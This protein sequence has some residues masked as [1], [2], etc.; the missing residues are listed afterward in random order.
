MNVMN[1]QLSFPRK[2]E[3]CTDCGGQV[4]KIRKEMGFLGEETCVDCGELAV[5]C[6][7]WL[8]LYTYLEPHTLMPLSS[9]GV[10][11]TSL[12][13]HLEQHY[14]LEIHSDFLETPRSETPQSPSATLRNKIGYRCQFAP[15]WSSTRASHPSMYSRLQGK[16][17]PSSQVVTQIN[18]LHT[19]PLVSM[20]FPPEICQQQQ[21]SHQQLQQAQHHEQQQTQQQKHKQ[22]KPQSLQRKLQQLPVNKPTTAS[23]KTPQEAKTP[24]ETQTK[25]TAAPTA[26]VVPKAVAP[27]TPKQTGSTGKAAA[28]AAPTSP[29]V[30]EAVAPEA[31]VVV[32]AAATPTPTA[33]VVPKA[34]A[35]AAAKE[36]GSIGKAAATAAPTAA[37]TSP[38]VPEAVAPAA[39]VAVT[40]PATSTP[41]AYV[42]P[43]AVAPAAAK[44]TGSIGK[45]A[46][47]AA[48]TA[49]PTSPAVPEAVA[50]A[51]AVAVVAPATPTPTAYVVPKAVAPAAAKETGSIGKAA[52]T[53]APTAAPTS[54]AVPE[55]V[56]PAAAVAVVAPATPTPTAYVVPKAVAPAAA[57]ETGSIGKAA[58]TAAPTSPAVPEAV[59]PAAAVAVVAAAT[60]TPTAYVVP[61]A[62][63]PATAKETGSIGKAAATAAPTTPT[64]PKAVALA[65]AQETG[66]TGKA[67]ATAASAL[68]VVASPCQQQST[69]KCK[70]ST[71]QRSDFQLGPKSSTVEIQKPQPSA[72]A[73]PAGAQAASTTSSQGSSPGQQQ[74][75]HTSPKQP[76]QRFS[77]VTQALDDYLQGINIPSI[78]QS[79]LQH[80]PQGQVELGQGASGGVLMMLYNNEHVAVKCVP[81]GDKDT[82]DREVRILSV[83]SEHDSFPNLHGTI[84]CGQ[85]RAVA[86]QFIG[87]EASA[88]C[89]TLGEALNG[90]R[91][92][93]LDP[94]DW[95]SI[96]MNVV[97]GIKHMH[98][99]G[100]LHNDIKMD[101]ILMS[102][103]TP[104]HRWRA[105]V[106]DVG[107]ATTTINPRNYVLT[108][109]EKEKY[110]RFHGH[111]APEMVDNAEHQSIQS[112]I[113]QLGFVLNSIGQFGAVPFLEQ[114]G[115][116]C[117][118]RDPSERPEMTHIKYCIQNNTFM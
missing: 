114:L 69:T 34:V 28:T 78:E 74:S 8:H 47:T 38:A 25:P 58:A 99:E 45:A 30:P 20:H 46:A 42:V 115:D 104:T 75:E 93:T 79:D 70:T 37:P 4:W 67:A 72:A 63:A 52:A 23:P 7:H 118:S 48:P 33:Y 105:Y 15:V 22:Q 82:V 61:K 18:Q 95:R 29:A 41:T 89:L 26:S 92:L 51:A 1:V 107:M 59:A 81:T 49:A 2:R 55:A 71:A 53:A 116:Q 108:S 27:P 14:P 35:P 101:N 13:F 94:A 36:T 76:K 56:A 96:A 113:F 62:V 88:T 64:V 66:S 106:I 10:Q 32:V 11:S 110:R 17:N 117:K 68:Y 98:S 77:P 21:Y 54:P 5:T 6:Q 111:I 12:R 19:T 90:S 3:S 24:D 73:L 16:T 97:D 39:A 103:D 85:F 80:P 31:A 43:K 100:L 91:S 86:M 112:D 87:D 84:D 102:N 44:E 40:A 60:P 9:H 65:A 109:E 50:P 83:L 57:T